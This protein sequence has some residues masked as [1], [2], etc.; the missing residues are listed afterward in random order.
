MATDQPLPTPPSTALSGTKHVVEEHLGEA[1][2]AVEPREAAD[3][4]ARGVQRHEEVGQAV[5][6]L[7]LRVGAE[8]PEQVRAE[9]PAGGPGLLPVQLPAARRPRRAHGCVSEARSLPAPG[10]DQPWHHRS[11]AR[12]HAR[13]QRVLLLLGAEGEQRRREQEDAVL[14]HP[15]RPAGA[16]V[17]LLEGEPLPDADAPRPPYC[18]G[19]DTTAQRAANSAAPTRRW[20]AKPSRVSPEGSPRGHVRRSATR[21]PRRGRPARPR[22][23]AGPPGP[24][25]SKR[26]VHHRQRPIPSTKTLT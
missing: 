18:S 12:G 19:Q 13:Q 25:P 6:P 14:R 22:S 15:L 4:H 2:V 21:G 23:R 1:L 26:L 5:V 17:L 11:S 10:S 20:R 7:R 8:Q 24:L 9:G 16:V 3:G